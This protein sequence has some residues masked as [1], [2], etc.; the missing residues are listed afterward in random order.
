MMRISS[1]SFGQGDIIPRTHTVDGANR[2]PPLSWSGIPNKAKT[3]ALVVED[4]DAPDPAA[5]QRIFAHWILY[6]LSPMSDGL[7]LGVGRGALPP[8]AR[9]GR[10]D[11]GQVGYGGPAPPAGRHRYFFRLFALDVVL[12]EGDA[13]D[14]A[15]LMRAIQGHVVEEAELMGTY[16][17]VQ[18]SAHAWA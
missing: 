11:F 1:P 8:P 2:S 14:R 7:A 6:N 10:N 3:L 13:F 17:R 15:A 16:E 4:P 18:V 12:P 5:P 9:A